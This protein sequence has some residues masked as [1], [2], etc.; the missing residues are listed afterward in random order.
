MISN[1]EELSLDNKSIRMIL[2]CELSPELFSNV[3]VVKLCF[4]A[5]KSVFSL[6]GFLQRLPNLENL[7]VESCALKELFLIED[8][9]ILPLPRVRAVKLDGVHDLK[10][11]WKTSSLLQSP[12]F[13]YLE[14]LEVRSCDDLIDLAPSSASFQN[15]TTVKIYECNGLKNLFTPSVA[16]TLVQLARLT[17]KSCVSLT[18]IVAS[19][20]SGT[21]DEI[22][23]S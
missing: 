17:A 10:N 18:E 12:L 14:T 7:I 21:I 13:E 9:M 1:L 2:D 5:S 23:F 3:K 22:V 15:L 6:F 8:A 11:I 16:K 19:E 4:F 20:Q